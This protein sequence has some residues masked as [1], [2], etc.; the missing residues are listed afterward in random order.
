MS[1]FLW[2]VFTYLHVSDVKSATSPTSST[3]SSSVLAQNVTCDERTVC[4]HN[5]FK[6]SSAFTPG[7][8]VRSEAEQSAL[9]TAGLERSGKPS[10]FRQRCNTW[11]EEERKG[12]ESQSDGKLQV[13]VKKSMADV[14]I[15][16][17]LMAVTFPRDNAPNAIKTESSG[18][19]KN[20]CSYLSL[21]STLSF[22]LP[23]RFQSSVS[24][25]ENKDTTC[26]LKKSSPLAQSP[27]DMSTSI[28]PEHTKVDPS[29]TVENSE[30]LELTTLD[31]QNRTNPAMIPEEVQT[32][33]ESSQMTNK[34]ID[35]HECHDSSSQ[36]QTCGSPSTIQ[37][38]PSSLSSSS[39]AHKCLSV[40][41]KIK[42]LN[43]HLYYSSKY[44]KI[45]TPADLPRVWSNGLTG[46]AKSARIVNCGV[47]DCAVCFGDVN[48]ETEQPR[49]GKSDGIEG[50]LQPDHWLFQQEEE[51]LEDIWRGKMG[52]LASNCTLG[53]NV[54]EETGKGNFI[55]WLLLILN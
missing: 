41:T 24:E 9:G 26:D 25:L 40:H 34:D 32:T 5:T 54:D 18:P 10:I 13:F 35:E 21:G 37:G 8:P 51:E 52:N 42:D 4:E 45:N 38:S 50:L 33:L 14:V 39:C 44:I 19:V 49:A 31:T 23:K 30:E 36:H 47:R 15:Q 46:S 6:A 16:D 48:K 22:C 27:T 1:L 3:H 20:I 7:E 2:Q 55:V 28:D 53:K 12:K 17:K 43:G 29:C 11:P